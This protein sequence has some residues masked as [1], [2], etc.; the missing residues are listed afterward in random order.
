MEEGTTSSDL[1]DLGVATL[2]EASGRRG[3]MRGIQLLVGPPFAGPAV[4]V[5]LP[6]GDNLGIHLALESVQPSDV[7]CVGSAGRGRYGVFGDLLFESARQR[8]LAGIVLDDGVR[9]IDELSPPPSLAARGVEAQGTIKARVR[10]PVGSDVA[11]G[12]VLISN[13]DWIVCDRDGVC[14]LPA[15]DLARIV[16]AARAR[17]EKESVIRAQLGLGRTTRDVLGLPPSG[18]PSIS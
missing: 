8:G 6:A 18:P 17:V 9:D 14:V 16:V 5:S 13:N 12:G 2:H 10:Q 1:V 15:S 7:I 3:L 4:T 11:I